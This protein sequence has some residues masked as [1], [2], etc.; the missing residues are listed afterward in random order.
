MK[1]L[2]IAIPKG[3]LLAPSLALLE[4]SG[5]ISP[6]WKP[7]GNRLI[8]EAG[9]GVRLFILRDEDVP[10]YVEY[11]AADLGIVGKDVL[12]EQPKEVYEPLD[13]KVGACRLVLVRPEKPGR[14]W[15]QEGHLRV[16]T[17]HPRLTEQYF[18][19]RGLQAEIIQLSGSLELAPLVGLA[20][21]IVDVVES[22]RTLRAHQLVQVEVLLDSTARLIENR[23]SHKLHYRRVRD[24]IGRLETAVRRRS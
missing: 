1:T 18:A 20:D 4:R 23:A 3:R 17:K 21:L 13:L 11:G 24:V 7:D 15:R 8:G 14:P 5:L 6:A 16:A 10:T 19:R 22:G 12:L 9:H 2:T